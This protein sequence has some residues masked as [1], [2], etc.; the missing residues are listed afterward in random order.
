M[1]LLWWSIL[2]A[3]LL[4]PPASAVDPDRLTLSR[5]QQAYLVKKQRLLFCIDPNWLPFE[6]MTVN[7]QHTGMSADYAEIFRRMLP[8]PLEQ[9]KTDSW[10]ESLKAAKEHRCDMLLMA[11]DVASRRNDFL[12]TP[13]YLTVPSAIATTSD[14]PRIDDLSQLQGKSIGIRAGVGFIDEFE[15]RFPQ[16]K[17]VQV[18]TYEEGFLQVENGDLYGLLGN[19]GSLTMLMQKYKMTNL[20]IAGQLGDD[21][22]I[23]VATRIDEPELNQIMTTALNRISAAQHQ[24]IMDKWIHVQVDAT[25]DYQ[26]AMQLSVLF[27]LAGGLAA[28]AFRKVRLLN[29]QLVQANVLLEQQSIRD[30]L[31]G[32]YNRHY[33]DEQLPAV[34]ALCQRQQLP[35]TVAMLDLDHFKQLN[36]HYGHVFGDHCLQQFSLL[37]QKFFTRPYDMLFRFGGE[38]FVLVSSGVPAAVIETRLSQ[39]L[40]EFAALP[41]EFA[42]IK[43]HG[44]VSIGCLCVVPPPEV[45][46]RHLFQ[47]ADEALY[48][49][50]HQGRNQLVRARDVSSVLTDY[51]TD[52]TEDRPSTSPP[53]HPV[54]NHTPGTDEPTP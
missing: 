13:S 35:L 47:L 34:L 28:V 9:L 19:M 36:D 4:L 14:K 50:K 54:Q 27:V 39:F 3:S 17:F 5:S 15:V 12:F 45:Q 2:V 32:L 22:V 24:Q 26:L 11:M 51:K 7:G 31:T 44:T 21:T 6:G 53:V 20:K 33:L 42:D 10:P 8:V 48:R 41:L 52:K 23:S 38:E 29:S 46:P 43:T 16:V 49:A 40:T 1:K 18:Q 30:R 37:L 25:R